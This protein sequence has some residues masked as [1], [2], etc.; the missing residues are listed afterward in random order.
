MIPTPSQWS[1]W[2]ADNGAGLLSR[3]SSTSWCRIQ[4]YSSAQKKKKNALEIKQRDKKSEGL[5]TELTDRLWI[6]QHLPTLRP[7][8]DCRPGA[9]LTSQDAISRLK[10]R[11]IIGKTHESPSKLIIL[12]KVYREVCAGDDRWWWTP[13]CSSRSMMNSTG[14]CRTL[15]NSHFFIFWDLSHWLLRLPIGVWVKAVQFLLTLPPFSSPAA[16][17]RLSPS[18]FTLGSSSLSRCACL[19]KMAIYYCLHTM[20]LKVLPPSWAIGGILLCNYILRYLLPCST[21]FHLYLHWKIAFDVRF[22]F[23]ALTWT[24]I[25]TLLSEGTG[26]ALYTYD[27]GRSLLHKPGM[28]TPRSLLPHTLMYQT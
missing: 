16:P 21:S 23:N 15:A 8:R 17:F 26:A 1:P 20:I 10:L 5:R 28:Y 4:I 24:C 18:Y 14:E 12:S 3:G 11:E 22:S 2:L 7:V 9:H 19:H 13:L 25:T 27:A 6:S